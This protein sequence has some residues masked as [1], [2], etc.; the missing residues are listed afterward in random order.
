MSSRSGKL[1]SKDLKQPDEFVTATGRVV[2]WGQE[3]RSTVQGLVGLFLLVLL[4]IVLGSLWSNS[5]NG[6]ANQEFYSAIELY[7][8]EQ[9]AEAY[10]GFD[11]LAES[12][13]GTD[14]GRLAAL[15]AGRSALKIGQPSEAT[16]HLEAYLGTNPPAGL[17][18][19]ARLDLGRAQASS[20]DAATASETL[21][22]ALEQ[23][24]PARP[25]ILIELARVEASAGRGDEAIALYTR[26]LE[27]EPDGPAVDLA[28]SRIRALGGTPPAEA[29]TPPGFGPGGMNGLQIRTQ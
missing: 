8:A 18:Q 16:R 1:T 13:G 26:Y 4:A 27:D 3:N 25:E 28:R 2:Q 14:Y 10:E 19:L 24:G 20:G 7:G 29:F 9:W 12:L 6:R 22:E 11:A 23:T 15:Y 21:R 17:A 5:R